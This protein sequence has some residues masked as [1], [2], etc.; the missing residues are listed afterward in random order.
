M[1]NSI[2]EIKG[3]DAFI[4]MGT[5]TTENHPVI[6]T[7]I[8]RR[9]KEG[10]KLIVIDPRQIELCKYADVYLQI[11]PGTNIAILNGIMNVIINEHLE[12]SEYIKNRTEGYEELKKVVEKYTPD[13]V[14]KICE[15]KEE[16]IIKAARIYGKAK[17]GAFYYAMGLTQH[18]SGT[19]SVMSASNVQL[20]T[21]N[22]GFE[23][24]GINPLRGQ[25]NVQGACDMGAL[26]TD[27]TGYQ[28]V[29]M[30]PVREA[31]EGF[32]HTDLPSKKGLTLT[33]MMNAAGS[34]DLG[35]LYIMGEN[36]MISDPDLN[37]VKKS[38]KNLDFLL[39]Q[40]IFLTE[41]A[42]VADVVLPAATFAEK[43]GTFTNTERRV[44]RVRKAIEPVGDS[45]PDWQILMELS[46]ILGLKE[47]YKNPSDI[48][49]EIATI[50]PSYRGISY[51]RLEKGSLQWPC[52]NENHPGT[53]Y[54]HK[55]TMARGKGLFMALEHEESKDQKDQEYP[56]ILTTGR[57]LYHYHTRT[58]TG[59]VEG[60]NA[61]ASHSYIEINPTT[62]KK[63][64]IKN[65]DLVRVSSK[66]GHIETY[67]KISD[68]VNE[69]TVFMPFHFSD[70]LVNTLTNA[71]ID[72][73]AKIPELKVATVNIEK[74]ERKVYG[75]SSTNN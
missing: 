68:I 54:L 13:V 25:N 62:A 16:D 35:F 6:G 4:I 14:A 51:E 29:F 2:A 5:N 11:K 22:I 47:F 67:A 32:W 44:L 64:N 33:E 20:L 15:V 18:T 31:M 34:G 70:G 58:M 75:Y 69:S 27:Y 73:I 45:K 23:S 74:V 39:V 10:A 53:M 59:K 65:G 24:T 8:K 28:K 1:T 42:Q 40:D 30:D 60:L 9:L 49:D 57:M 7:K 41:T 55:D 52:T 3:T 38:L 50:T 71:A 48:M 43:D 56:L 66:R 17:R 12:D 26:P 72:P 46:N 37:H 36:P 61:M 21:G 63:Y 19:H